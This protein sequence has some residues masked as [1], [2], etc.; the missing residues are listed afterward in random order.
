VGRRNYAKD[1]KFNMIH[2]IALS[3]LVMFGACYL[4]AEP[5]QWEGVLFTPLAVTG[6]GA[7]SQTSG[8][9]RFD[10]F[11][12]ARRDPSDVIRLHDQYYVFYTKMVKYPSGQ[13]GPIAP[14]YP[15]GY[16]YG[17][18]W[19]ATSKDAA[20]WTERTRVL[21]RGTAGAWD[22][23]AVFTPNIIRGLDDELYLYYTA[24]DENGGSYNG[25]NPFDNDSEHD[26]TQIGVAR[27]HMDVNGVITGAT[28]LNNSQP[29]LSPL[30]DPHFAGVT[31]A[32]DS[33]RVDDA[34]LLLR[35]FDG[36]GDL[37]YGLYYKGRAQGKT[38]GETKMG[39][40]I[41]DRPDR[42]FVRV[43]G[44]GKAIQDEGHEVLVWA[45]GEGVGSFVLGSGRGLWYASDAVH[46]REITESFTGSPGGAPGAY[47]PELVDHD[48]RGGIQWGV[49]H[50]GPHPYLGTWRETSGSLLNST[51]AGDLNGDGHVDQRDLNLLMANWQKKVAKGSK[52]DGD[53]NEDGLIDQCDRDILLSGWSDETSPIGTTSASN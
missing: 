53:L 22:S 8:S 39:L 32:F 44:D 15:A 36:D 29:I 20:S 40:A 34:S 43:R 48:Y 49:R 33:F 52:Y 23:F 26:I 1:W 14:T 42:G 12:V 5:P 21:D 45:Q 51:Q 24:V 35:D 11:G 50:V 30:Y 38:A 7:D 46:F 10:R 17:E 18:I 6:I 25:D 28:R 19:Y 47:R 4:G 3:I 31:P 37:E 9:G 2:R 16:A 13:E 41:S 27:L